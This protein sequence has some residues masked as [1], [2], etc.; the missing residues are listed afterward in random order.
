MDWL[1][2]L[3]VLI[4]ASDDEADCAARV[5]WNLRSRVADVLELTAT[6][7]EGFFDVRQID[8]ET[9]ALRTDDSTG[10]QS[11]FHEFEVGFL[12]ER[13]SGTC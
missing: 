8:P 9:A 11:F 6:S 4:Q 10:P 12:E 3:S 2:E 1:V 5:R 13:D 7:F